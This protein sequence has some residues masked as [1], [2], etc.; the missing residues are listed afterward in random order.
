[1]RIVLLPFLA[2]ALFACSRDPEHLD[3]S[4]AGKPAPAAEFQDPQG[5]SVSLSDFRGK[6]LLVNLWATWCAP[7][8]TELPTLDA[9]A[10][11]EDGRLQVLA[12]SQDGDD[13]AKV[14]SFLAEHKLSALE[15]YMDPKLAL[16]PELGVE[17]LPTTILYDSEG[18]ELWRMA[19]VADW[20]D[21]GSAALI[22]EAFN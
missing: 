21:A 17:I 1:M 10:A 20:G 19:G 15:A 5:R 2:L 12:I 14:E 6:P 18:R 13:R 4:Q 3:R 16:M 22:G 7:C 9:L 8:V 11:R